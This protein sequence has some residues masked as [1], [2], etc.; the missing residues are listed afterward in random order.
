MKKK[1]PHG[2]VARERFWKRVVQRWEASEHESMADFCRQEGLPVKAFY[3]WRERI[4]ASNANDGKM[5][6][7]PVDTKVETLKSDAA[8]LTNSI[9]VEIGGAVGIVLQDGFDSKLL[10]SVVA[11]LIC[12]FLMLCL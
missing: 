3:S 9:R 10:R 11:A 4:A 12:Y 5:H 7:L 8:A 1:I 6:F 2:M